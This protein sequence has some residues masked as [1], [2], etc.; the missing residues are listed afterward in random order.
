MIEKLVYWFRRVDRLALAFVVAPTFL[1]TIYFGLVASDVYVSE[2]KFVVRSPE[3][4]VASPLG[5]VLAGV[6]FSKAQDDSFT[7]R[8]FILSRD[9]LRVLNE[10]V[11]L[12]EAYAS[13]RVDPI[14]RF[15]VL[16][17]DDSFEAL[18]RYYQGKV[19]VVTDSG[20]GITTLTVR[21]FGADKSV[22]ANRLLLEQS[23]A[24]VNRLNERGRQDLVGYARQEVVKAQEMAL[25]SALALAEYRVKQE[26]MDPEKQGVNQLAQV[27][28]LQDELIAMRLQL[29]QLQAL[30]PNNPQM[31]AVQNRIR[32]LEQEIARGNA[33]VVGEGNSLAL[34]STEYQRLSLEAEFAVKNLAS[35]LAGYENALSEAQRQQAYLERIAQPSKPDRAQEPRRLRSI[36]ITFLLGLVVYG[37]ASMLVAGIREHMD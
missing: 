23:E 33:R 5:A 22:V 20:S 35:A 27:A 8:E 4:K 32:T 1:S 36:F 15:G 11:G 17:L 14:N 13:K 24:L 3:R 7:V 37:I 26:V 34:K 21:A 9:A 2:S 6:G 30:T 10:K 19:T 25:K 12:G 29:A 16:D 28:K 18:Y 31:P